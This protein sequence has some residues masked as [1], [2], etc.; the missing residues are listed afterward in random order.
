MVPADLLAAG[1]FDKPILLEFIEAAIHGALRK[2]GVGDELR[3]AATGMLFDVVEYSIEL[4][5]R[6][7]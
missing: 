1:K 7:N 3:G 5:F 4:F 6:W 2:G